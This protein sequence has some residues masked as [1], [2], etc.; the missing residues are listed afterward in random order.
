[1]E[2]DFEAL[3][4]VVGAFFAGSIAAEDAARHIVALGFG[5]GFA[6]GGDGEKSTHLTAR[7][8]ANNFASVEKFRMVPEGTW[9]CSQLR[10]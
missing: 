3:E 1:M 8:D 5:E 9:G 7:L 4:E 2:Q 10:T 6:F